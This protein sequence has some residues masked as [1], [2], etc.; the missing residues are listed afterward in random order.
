M[1]I[2]R[3]GCIGGHT[4][5][6]HSA[7]SSTNP[8][9]AKMYVNPGFKHLN[10]STSVDR[11]NGMSQQQQADISSGM[12]DLLGTT[13]LSSMYFSKLSYFFSYKPF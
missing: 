1:Y 4:C 11:G 3:K 12:Y 7:A 10:P 8:Q 9:D 5:H 13:P 6:F 2:T